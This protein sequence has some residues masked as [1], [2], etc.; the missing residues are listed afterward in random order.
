MQQGTA[1]ARANSFPFPTLS[2]FAIYSSAPLL[3]PSTAKD[4]PSDD[5]AIE[6][7]K[8]LFFS[9]TQEPLPKERKARLMGTVIG[10]ADFARY[11]SRCGGG[12]WLTC[13]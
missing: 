11:V 7:S 13:V 8:L 4:A 9:S 6:A 10:M 3:E 1:P 12:P 5:A 2:L